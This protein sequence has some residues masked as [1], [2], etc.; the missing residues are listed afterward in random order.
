MAGVD[1]ATTPAI[2][3]A[4][5]ESVRLASVGCGS[6]GL[7]GRCSRRCGTDRRVDTYGS[8]EHQHEARDTQ[9]GDHGCDTGEEKR[10]PGENTENAECRTAAGRA[11]SR[12][13]AKAGGELGVFGVEG[14]LH[15][16]K[17]ALLVL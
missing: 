3:E 2:F 4:V 15:L 14:A 17:Q 5:H 11:R 13:G 12:G 8:D 6:C 10:E 1:A 9:G 16:L 7:I